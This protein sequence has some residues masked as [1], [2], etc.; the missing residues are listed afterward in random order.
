MNSV[1]GKD[2]NNVRSG[3]TVGNQPDGVL[4][5]IAA[6]M[7]VAGIESIPQAQQG[8][9]MLGYSMDEK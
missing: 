5:G 3:N 2:E 9:L 1:F 4:Q 8:P 6:T 7:E